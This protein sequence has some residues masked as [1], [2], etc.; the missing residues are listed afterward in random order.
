MNEFE[1]AAYLGRSL[2]AADRERVEIH[3]SQCDFCRD[4]VVATQEAVSQSSKPGRIAIV[5]LTAA[6]AV[7]ALI[8]APRFATL[9]NEPVMRDP[10]G[11]VGIRAYD[12]KIA[13]ALSTVFA[14][15]GVSTADHYELTL[16]DAEGFRIWSG[17]TRDTTIALPSSVSLIK[18]KGYVWYADAILADGSR[19]STGLQSLSSSR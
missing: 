10:A 2:S 7:M 5:S 3:L 9:R 13:G 16:T 12:A 8:I 1:V 4:A 18:G 14:W 11:S 17:E 6:A 15:S 19:I